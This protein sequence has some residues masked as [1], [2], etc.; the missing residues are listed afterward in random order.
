VSDVRTRYA[1]RV[2]GS[3]VLVTGARGFL[4]SHLVPL[5]VELGARVHATSRKPLAGASPEVTGHAGVFEG[6][7]E[8]E[9]LLADAD[10]D[11]VFHFAGSVS[12][13][14]GVEHVVPTFHSL[15]ESTVH[16]L[17]LASRA[18][19]PR[20]VLAGSFLEPRPED[21][22]P[23]L[24]SGYAAAKWAGSAYARMFW[25]LYETPVVTSVPFMVYGPGQQESKLLPYVVRSLL[26]GKVPEIGSGERRADWV[27]A[28]DVA[29]GL[30][31]CGWEPRALGRKL[32]LGSGELVSVRSVVD[33]VVQLIGARLGP[34]YGSLAPRPHEPER[35]A[36]VATAREILGWQAS[37]E[38]R[39]GLTRTI[40]S[41]RGGPGE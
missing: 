4:G 8:L 24:G 39:D 37:T 22:E 34:R 16:L 32:D 6:R 27:Y 25:D 19:R 12:G 14:S 33:Q 31:A 1:A 9:R 36:D 40:E 20:V 26:A 21:A 30:V 5:L 7:T 38:L 35:V 3:R 28:A 2:R 15:L 29:L 23:R 18:R 17:E 10:P 41:L 11:V 13:A